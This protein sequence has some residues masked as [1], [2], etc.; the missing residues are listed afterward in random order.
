MIDRDRLKCFIELNDSVGV[1]KYVIMTHIKED[2]EILRD[3]L[4]ELNYHPAIPLDTLE[5]MMNSFVTDNGYDCAWR[6]SRRMGIAWNN[7][8]INW[9]KVHG[10][11][12]IINLC[13]DGTVQVIDTKS[14]PVIPVIRNGKQLG[15]YCY[16]SNNMEV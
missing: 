8:C 9:W 14:T 10:Q 16:T 6:I 4:V 15:Y 12:D 7:Q 11:L 5:N 1:D 3:I 13:N 2:F